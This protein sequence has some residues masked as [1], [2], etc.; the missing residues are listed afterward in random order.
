MT[1]S[2]ERHLSWSLATR[3]QSLC[4]L[5]CDLENY[6]FVFIFIFFKT[7]RMA[8]PRAIAG[9]Y[10]VLQRKY[11]ENAWHKRSTPKMLAAIAHALTMSFS[12]EANDKF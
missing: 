6:P 2:T 10:L 12:Y 3:T 8:P 1:M 4:L 5:L 11:V 7:E 9:S